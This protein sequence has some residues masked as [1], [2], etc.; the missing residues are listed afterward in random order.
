M[1]TRTPDWC[2]MTDTTVKNLVREAYANSK[3][4]GFH[5]D[6]E[7]VTPAHRLMLIT[8]EVN[9]AFE[10]IRDGRDLV[11]THYTYTYVHDGVKFKGLNIDQYIALAGHEPAF[12]EGVVP[13]P[14][15][16]PSELA[17]VVIRIFDFAGTYGIDLE[18]AI[19]QKMNYNSGRERLHGRTF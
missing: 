16:V 7:S 3:A 1:T 19:V 9:E 2:R 5:D 13:K 10:E 6:D 8:G 15:G 18:G 14:E 17:D 12:D 4:K 11:E